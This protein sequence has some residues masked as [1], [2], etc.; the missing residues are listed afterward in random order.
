MKDSIVEA[1]N[2]ESVLMEKGETQLMEA[3][4]K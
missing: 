3:P 2:E 1:H 4:R